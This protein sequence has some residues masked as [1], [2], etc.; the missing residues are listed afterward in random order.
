MQPSG[1][2]LSKVI[3]P[4]NVVMHAVSSK[5][6]RMGYQCSFHADEIGDL[7]VFTDNPVLF[8]KILWEVA[9][10]KIKEHK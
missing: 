8:Q 1:R 6:K 2:Q 10:E 5:M 4:I 9:N 7:A 3:I